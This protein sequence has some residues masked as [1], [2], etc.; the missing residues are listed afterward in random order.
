MA[1]VLLLYA[2]NVKGSFS[3]LRFGTRRGRDLERLKLQDPLARASDLP[4][5]TGR[6]RGDGPSFLARARTGIRGREGPRPG[7][8]EGPAARTKKKAPAFAGAYLK[9]LAP[10]DLGLCDYL[11]NPP[12]QPSYPLATVGHGVERIACSTVAPWNRPVMLYAL[13]RETREATTGP[14]PSQPAQRPT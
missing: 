14:R 11:Q 5:R 6:G 8:G 2:R 4:P 13:I 1:L 3:D 9:T 12:V 7:P 10:R